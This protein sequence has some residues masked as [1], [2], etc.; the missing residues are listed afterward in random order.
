VDLRSQFHGGI[1]PASSDSR[2]LSA[3]AGDGNL[4]Y[5]PTGGITMA[6]PKAV[7]ATIEKKIQLQAD[8]CTRMEL[9]LFSE[10]EGKIPYGAQSEFINKLIREH[11]KKLDEM[12]CTALDNL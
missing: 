4:Q 8:L 7:I 12:T 6:R 10:V 5:N 9:E 11:Y 2:S 1:G 3:T